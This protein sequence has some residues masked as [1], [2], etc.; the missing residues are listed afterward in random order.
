MKFRVILIF[1]SILLSSSVVACV[2]PTQ[3][4]EYDDLVEVNWNKQER[5]FYILFPNEADGQKFDNVTLGLL[6]DDEPFASTSAPL[7]TYPKNGKLLTYVR[8]FG[9]LDIGLNVSVWWQGEN[10]VCPIIGKAKLVKK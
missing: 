10:D 2:A 6:K 1:I 7:Q 9:D 5:S 3:G 4:K 8:S